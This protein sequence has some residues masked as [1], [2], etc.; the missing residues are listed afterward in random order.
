MMPFQSLAPGVKRECVMLPSLR[1]SS[2]DFEAGTSRAAGRCLE[3]EALSASGKR[4]P[5]G[6][7]TH[8]RFPVSGS[9][10]LSQKRAAWLEYSSA[11]SC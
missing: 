8:A 5:V 10:T 6:E 11:R 9:D 2:H 1:L 4:L 7:R 3:S